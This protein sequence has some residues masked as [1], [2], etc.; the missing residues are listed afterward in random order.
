M[1]KKRKHTVYVYLD[2]MFQTLINPDEMSMV[3]PGSDSEMKVR[4]LLTLIQ[5][6]SSQKTITRPV[7]KHVHV[8]VHKPASAVAKNGAPHPAEPCTAKGTGLVA[9]IV[10][11]MCKFNVFVNLPHDLH[12]HIEIKGPNGEV[13]SE[14]I[15]HSQ[16]SLPN[17]AHPRKISLLTP[18]DKRNSIWDKFCSKS[19]RFWKKPNSGMPIVREKSIDV[20]DGKRTKQKIPFD[21]QCISEVHYV[22]TYIPRNTG[23]HIVHVKWCEK[24]IKGSPFTVKIFESIEKL[25]EQSRGRMFQKRVLFDNKN[26]K[27]QY[28]PQESIDSHSS[29]KS[30]PDVSNDGQVTALAIENHTSKIHSTLGAAIKLT[31]QATITRRRVL[32]RVITKAG[33]EIVIHEAPAS[34]TPPPNSPPLGDAMAEEPP[35]RLGSPAPNKK[36]SKGFDFGM[37]DDSDNSCPGTPDNS[38][39]VQQQKAETIANDMMDSIMTGVFQTIEQTGQ[40]AENYTSSEQNEEDICDRQEEQQRKD[41]LQPPLFDA[42]FRG[43]P[44]VNGD[45]LI[46]PKAI[47]ANADSNDNSGGE[48]EL[49]TLVVTESRVLSTTSVA[50]TPKLNFDVQLGLPK[51]ATKFKSSPF[52]RSNSP[53]DRGKQEDSESYTS[54][55]D[56]FTSSR[57]RT[58]NYKYSSSCSTSMSE[59]GSMRLDSLPPPEIHIE[60]N[61]QGDFDGLMISNNASTSDDGLKGSTSD[62]SD[63]KLEPYPVTVHAQLED[64]QFSQEFKYPPRKESEPKM[65]SRRN[66]KSHSPGRKDSNSRS[67]YHFKSNVRND[68][69][70]TLIGKKEVIKRTLSDPLS[71]KKDRPHTL[72]RADTTPGSPTH[73]LK[74]HSLDEQT[75]IHGS[76]SDSPSLKVIQSNSLQKSCFYITHKA[77]GNMGSSMKSQNSVESEAMVFHEVPNVTR[78]VSADRPMLAKQRSKQSLRLS[79]S[80]PTLSKSWTAFEYDPDDEPMTLEESE[81]QSMSAHKRHKRATLACS[82]LSDDFGELSRTY[83]NEVTL[84]DLRRLQQTS[85]GKNED[86]GR[87]V[88][89]DNGNSLDVHEIDQLQFSTMDSSPTKVSPLGSVSE[90][91]PSGSARNSRR[92]SLVRQDVIFLKRVSEEDSLETDKSINIEHNDN[93]NELSGHPND[94]VKIRDDLLEAY[95]A[96]S[97]HKD[98]YSYSLSLS[99]VPVVSIK[100]PKIKINRFTQVS[101]DEIKRETG[102]DKPTVYLRHR[103]MQVKPVSI[104]EPASIDQVQGKVL[105]EFGDNQNTADSTVKVYVQNVYSNMSGVES[106]SSSNNC[107]HSN[108][109][110]MVA[111][112]Q[113]RDHLQPVRQSTVET[114][115]SGIA[116]DHVMSPQQGATPRASL[117][118]SNGILPRPS[119]RFI[120]GHRVVTRG[121]YKRQVSI[122]AKILKNIIST[123]SH[124]DDKDNSSSENDTP[125]KKHMSMTRFN[126]TVS[127]SRKCKRRQQ[128]REDTTSISDSDKKKGIKRGAKSVIGTHRRRVTFSRRV[129]MYRRSSS[130]S[131]KKSSRES[132]ESRDSQQSPKSS[133]QT[134]GQAEPDTKN[135]ETSSDKTNYASALAAYLSINGRMPRHKRK[136]DVENWI[137]Q[138]SRGSTVETSSI[139]DPLTPPPHPKNI[140]CEKNQEADVVDC[141]YPQKVD[142]KHISGDIKHTLKDKTTEMSE[143]TSS[144]QLPIPRDIANKHAPADVQSSTEGGSYCGFGVEPES[145][146]N[147]LLELNMFSNITSETSSGA[148]QDLSSHTTIPN[149]CTTVEASSSSETC[150]EVAHLTGFY[151]NNSATALQALQA[152]PEIAEL[153][154]SALAED[155]SVPCISNI[156]DTDINLG[157]LDVLSDLSTSVQGSSNESESAD[158]EAHIPRP[159]NCVACGA[160]LAYGQVGIKNNFQ[161]SQ[162]F[163]IIDVNFVSHY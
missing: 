54:E 148:E 39:T 154:S 141:T 90:S 25:N 142:S 76:G 4:H 125:N 13:C 78:K 77:I 109:E 72:E 130:R 68:S 100:V 94:S 67:P 124:E 57:E 8:P 35:I 51:D 16:T 162:T 52:T 152:D 93:E 1:L 156:A 97:E 41:S 161:V 102:W 153:L 50:V 95:M 61:D 20:D 18:S 91:S 106:M 121:R 112:E 86:Y 48:E 107:H 71:H 113:D 134:P 44:F 60:I 75:M 42:N 151:R 126:R 133:F 46:K 159:N 135:V 140:C 58:A 122:D 147:L 49:P 62:S 103:R 3:L 32:R 5:W 30:E 139:D 88:M 7:S 29:D 137:S 138:T 128:S 96:N 14:K 6:S 157:G 56:S 99:N 123:T 11:K 47:K 145:R 120:N 108:G 55:S 80:L 119:P 69:S 31:K 158:V 24:D 146:N 150:S 12:L 64:F 163:V 92:A 83:E 33:Q 37:D 144:D 70:D 111:A 149:T 34:P 81:A 38:S 2:C 87:Q 110:N 131:S 116:D 74:Q 19:I 23:E 15:M 82:D 117:E 10:G 36:I 59:A 98:S 27:M 155:L 9:G 115:D 143:N 84:D 104:E 101:Y 45:T 114:I 89:F 129:M 160:G 26:A 118:N 85:K 127:D 28:Y 17:N 66:S 63:S 65:S 43:S 136:K 40:G 21:Y 22:I 132:R 105:G 53:F 73:N 79:M